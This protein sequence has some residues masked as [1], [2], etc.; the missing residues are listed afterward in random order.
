MVTENSGILQADV[1]I[2]IIRDVQLELEKHYIDHDHLTGKIR[3]LLCGRCNSAIGLAAE[4]ATRL[5]DLADYLEE[6]S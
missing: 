1:G 2:V 6:N 5:R 3:G 4:S